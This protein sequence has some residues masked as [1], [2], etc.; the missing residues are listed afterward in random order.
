MNISLPTKFKIVQAFAP[1]TTNAALTSQ[2]VTLKGAIKAWLVLNFTQA[3]GFASTP[4]IKQATD[5]AA[6]PTPP[7]RLPHL[8]EPRRRGDRHAGRATAAASYAV[9]HG[10]QEHD[11]R[12]RDRSGLAD[13][14]LRL[15]LLHDRDVVAGDEL[16]RGRVFVIQ[17]NFAQATPPSAI[18]D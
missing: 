3:V 6:A 5:I 11:G 14:R 15:R 12:L 10:R 16:R 17:T 1:K 9:S 8:V 13:R 18:L 7:G 4:T 2:V